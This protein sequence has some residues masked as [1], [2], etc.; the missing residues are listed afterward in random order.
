MHNILLWSNI[1][2][3]WVPSLRPDLAAP[4][5]LGTALNRVRT[6]MATKWQIVNRHGKVVKHG[7]A[8]GA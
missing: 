6:L 2:E 5:D 3:K 7:K 8:A 1:G 4:M